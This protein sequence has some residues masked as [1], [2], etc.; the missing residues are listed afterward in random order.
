MSEDDVKRG[1][2]SGWAAYLR[3]PIL[4]M[5]FPLFVA[6]TEEDGSLIGAMAF[7]TVALIVIY[8]LRW[9]KRRAR[10]LQ[11]L[12]G[13]ETELLVYTDHLTQRNI[14]NGETV[15]LLQIK[16]NEIRRADD[17]GTLLRVTDSEKIVLLPKNVIP[18]GSLLQYRLAGHISKSQ[19]RRHPVLSTLFILG[20]PLIL[21]LAA[22]IYVSV[23]G[24]DPSPADMTRYS[25]IMLIPLPFALALIGYG[26]YRAVKNQKKSVVMFI[27]GAVCALVAFV[28]AILPRLGV[29]A[30]NSIN[31][32]IAQIEQDAGVDLPEAANIHITNNMTVGGKNRVTQI[33]V[34]TMDRSVSLAFDAQIAEDPRW[35][36][37]A[38]AERLA[39]VW[40]GSYVAQNADYVMCVNLTDGTANEL[41]AE[42]GKYRCINLL[43]V[44]ETET[45]YVVRYEIDYRQ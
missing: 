29:G 12:G 41:P 6:V 8:S 43:Y 38:Q 33:L 27:V 4:L 31:N 9:R 1:I 13:R 44:R 10:L 15:S 40:N 37:S 17:L 21:I 23:I 18:D 20:V 36:T 26:I 32:T 19:S 30:K 35:I 11:I 7:W 14:K 25:W 22:N 42:N 3:A 39:P 45:I 16:Y 24:S 34:L 2:R 28:I 5:L